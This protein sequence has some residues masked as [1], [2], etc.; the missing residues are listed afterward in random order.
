MSVLL[1]I[2]VFAILSRRGSYVTFKQSPDGIKTQ[3]IDN[4]TTKKILALVIEKYGKNVAD[5]LVS[6]A[7]QDTNKRYVIIPEQTLSKW[8]YDILGERYFVVDVSLTNVRGGER[9]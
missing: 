4:Q 1:A 9:D 6:I 5:N 8:E 7:Y 2:S 3:N